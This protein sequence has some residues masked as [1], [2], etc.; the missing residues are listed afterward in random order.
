MLFFLD[1]VLS[2][3]RSCANMLYSDRPGTSS[4]RAL[5]LVRRRMPRGLR[6]LPF[7]PT[8]CCPSTVR[9]AL[10]PHPEKSEREQMGSAQPRRSRSAAQ[11]STAQRS[12]DPPR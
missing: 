2:A 5:C 1:V 9:L 12:A 4:R 6:G 7:P 3:D 8:V 11:R 10:P